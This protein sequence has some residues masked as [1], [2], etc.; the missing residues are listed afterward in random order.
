M[1]DTQD[2]HV[3]PGDVITA[4]WWNEMQRRLYA[5]V[6]SELAAVKTTVE[7]A[8]AS[9]VGMVAPFATETPPDGWLECNGQ[10][11]VRSDYETLFTL[12]GT[13]FGAGDGQH[14]FNV[15]DLRGIFIRGW[16]HGSDNDPGRL[17]RIA[18][19][20]GGAEG[21]SVGSYQP[22]QMQGHSHPDLGHTHSDSG[23]AHNV[24]MYGGY[25]LDRQW[26]YPMHTE[27]K[28]PANF[29]GTELGHANI[30]ENSAQLADP[31]DSGTGSGSPRLGSE[32][33]SKNIYLM[34]CIKI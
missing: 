11:I 8:D 33:C 30:T 23:H 21:D 10:S 13:R 22:D 27:W 5:H 3:Q 28:R 1:P 26:Q 16:A 2:L 24:R 17:E 29:V 25:R 31:I 14:T 9:L 20:Y 12:I 6:S 15:P 7:G 34:F 32:N 19:G 4:E 18:T